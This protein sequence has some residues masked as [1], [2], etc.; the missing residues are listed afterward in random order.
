MPLSKNQVPA[1]LHVM[2]GLKALR[3]LL[4][5]RTKTRQTKRQT[6]RPL[7]LQTMMVH[8]AHLHVTLMMKT[9]HR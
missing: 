3:L 6:K 8:K 7:P 4:K 1:F 5:A 9:Q 2:V